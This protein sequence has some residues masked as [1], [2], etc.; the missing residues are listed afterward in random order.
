MT[1]IYLHRAGLYDNREYMRRRMAD[2][3]LLQEHFPIHGCGA[4]G[5]SKIVLC[6][7][8]AG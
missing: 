8:D 1:G 2:A 6:T 4:A 5:S 7:I 3:K